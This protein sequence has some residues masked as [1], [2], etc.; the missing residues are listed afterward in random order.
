MDE[1]TLIDNGRRWSRKWRLY[2]QK[3]NSG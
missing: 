2:K 1:T 3:N